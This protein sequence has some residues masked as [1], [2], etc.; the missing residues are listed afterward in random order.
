[1]KA[2]TLVMRVS[3]QDTEYINMYIQHWRQ[4]FSIQ[5]ND[6]IIGSIFRLTEKD[7][8]EDQGKVLTSERDPPEI[9]RETDQDKVL[10]TEVRFL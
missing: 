3:C 9:D 10:G 4:S 7:P 2:V 8:T 6:R 1:M 5:T